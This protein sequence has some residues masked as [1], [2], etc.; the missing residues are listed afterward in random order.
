MPH[1]G[2]R[3]VHKSKAKTKVLLCGRGWGKD[4]CLCA[5]MFF[6]YA[7]WAD[8]ERP[9]W[10]VPKLNFVYL[11]PTYGAASQ[12]WIELKEFLHPLKSA[13]IEVRVRED[14]KK[15]VLPT[16]D[17]ECIIEL[18]SA[19]RPESLLGRGI[20]L[21]GITE[22]DDVPD[23]VY[24]SY[25][26]PM[27]RRAGRKGCAVI[28]GTPRREESYFHNLFKAGENP[29]VEDVESFHFTS[30]DN[31]Y[32]DP[33]SIYADLQT[34]PAHLWRQEY[35]AE[36]QADAQAA[37][38]N[39]DSCIGGAEEDPIENHSYVIG[40]DLGQKVDFTVAIV[41]DRERR[42]AVKL[43][44]FSKIDW[45]AQKTRI[46]ELSQKYNKAVVVIDS[47]NVGS[48][49]SQ[50][51]T[52]AGITVKDVN[53]HSVKEKERVVNA[54]ALALEKETVKFPS[55]MLPLI[56]ELKMYRRIAVN[57]KG[58]AL[59]VPTMRAPYG[60]HDDC[61][62]ALALALDGCPRYGGWDTP[63]K[64]REPAVKFF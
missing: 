50:D 29:A 54:L 60:K 4:R 49:F 31:P 32:V 16:H 14:E 41:M 18:S 12:N 57:K 44:R 59:K 52:H 56:A 61:V 48:S 42:R 7:A 24:E 25:V 28:V 64:K 20:D 2:Q 13:G 38:Q 34:M 43:D 8:E 53:F 55:S 5:E 19:D 33:D 37:F 15:I 26:R 47:A 63:M 30:F 51:L 40:L 39:I 11:A 23:V 21:L 27:L 10:L 46:A 35:L 6:K 22:A 62:I 1:E 45:P 9:E 3:V 17:G 36:V 58:E